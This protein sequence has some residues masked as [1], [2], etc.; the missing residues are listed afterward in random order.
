MTSKDIS[1]KESALKDELKSATTPAGKLDLDT[2]RKKNAPLA[3][4]IDEFVMSKTARDS[5]ETIA[6]DVATVLWAA[7]KEASS[8]VGKALADLSKKIK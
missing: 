1:Q 7:E 3:T 2:L 5:P 8:N 4:I 6:H